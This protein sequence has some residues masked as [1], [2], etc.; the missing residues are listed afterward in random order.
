M[1][2]DVRDVRMLLF[3]AKVGTPHQSQPQ[4]SDQHQ[5]LVQLVWGQARSPTEVG[6]RVHG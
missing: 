6:G 3:E 4:H 5:Q 2:A 1:P